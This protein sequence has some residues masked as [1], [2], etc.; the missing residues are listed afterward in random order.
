MNSQQVMLPGP[1]REKVQWLIPFQKMTNE[2]AAM[3]SNHVLLFGGQVQV[4]K[5]H[6]RDILLSLQ[7]EIKV[8][9]GDSSMSALGPQ[10]FHLFFFKKAFHASQSYSCKFRDYIKPWCVCTF[11][12]SA[13]IFHSNFDRM[14]FVH[15]SF[16]YFN[17]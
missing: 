12:H 14:L 16:M 4:L 5:V 10:F 3:K 1:A 2:T 13:F 6:S 15:V 11:T 9:S 17:C 8:A 7:L